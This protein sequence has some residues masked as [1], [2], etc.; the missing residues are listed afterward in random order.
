MQLQTA[1]IDLFIQQGYGATSTAQIAERAGV[2]ERT[3]FRVFTSK[4]GLVWHDPFVQRLLAEL[5]APASDVPHP[6][7][8][9]ADAVERAVHG[10][11]VDEWELNVS[12][13]QI[14]LSEPELIAAGTQDLAR[15]GRELLAAL[16]TSSP[17]LADDGHEPTRLSLFSWFSLIGFTQVPLTAK[18]GRDEWATALI[19]VV[20]LAAHGALVHRL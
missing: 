20:D 13:R 12:R 17:G 2:S 6:G 14:A 4:A 15:T 11:T 8:L 9:L 5:G 10:L 3:L 19:R 18:T 16:A 7:R 1:A